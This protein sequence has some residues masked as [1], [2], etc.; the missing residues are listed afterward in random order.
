MIKLPVTMLIASLV[1]QGCATRYA[2]FEGPRA[3][4]A[5]LQ[6][7]SSVKLLL[8]DGEA[9]TGVL[10]GASDD[11]ISLRTNQPAATVT[12]AIAAILSISQLSGHVSAERILFGPGGWKGALVFAAA[13]AV[14]AVLLVHDRS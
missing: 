7:G 3:T 10:V 8:S 13:M 11:A 1:L 5:G 6:V 12:V 14:A 2:G 9:L 4:R